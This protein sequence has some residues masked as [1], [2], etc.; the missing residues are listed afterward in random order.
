MIKVEKLTRLADVYDDAF[1]KG[2]IW[3]VTKILNDRGNPI[4]SFEY[5][6]DSCNL[7]VEVIELNRD[8]GL[9]DSMSL[10]CEM[11]EKFD[12]L[13]FKILTANKDAVEK[14]EYEL[15]LKLRKKFNE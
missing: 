5:I 9:K 6:D 1:L 4:D 10:Y 7:E 13:K 2:R 3:F 15:Y 8:N 11:H 12:D 14:A